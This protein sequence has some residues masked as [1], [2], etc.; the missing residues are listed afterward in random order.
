[1]PKTKAR[2]KKAPKGSRDVYNL[3]LTLLEQGRTEMRECR[4]HLQE[5]S[6]VVE[7]AKERYLASA[8]RRDVPSQQQAAVLSDYD[9]SLI[10]RSKL[11]DKCDALEKNMSL[12]YAKR[13][14]FERKHGSTSTCPICL[15]N[16]LITKPKTWSMQRTS[17]DHAFH[18]RCLIDALR[19]RGE[20]C[21]VCQQPV[22]LRDAEAHAVSHHDMGVAED[23]H[24]HQVEEVLGDLH[25]DERYG[26][27]DRGG[28]LSTARMG[29]GGAAHAHAA[30]AEHSDDE[31]LHQVV[32][33]TKDL[34]FDEH[35]GDYDR[36]PYA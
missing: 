15:N 6:H 14:A 27:Y 11:A 16:M 31:Q 5:Y 22:L 1:M 28:V 12:L 26:D 29:G 13:D 8:N 25:L 32:E 18:T 2:Q 17:C 24:L 20:R 23:E 7:T 19:E 36:A 4:A 9:R 34:Q 35:Y 3:I 10:T 30:A 33:D 21:P